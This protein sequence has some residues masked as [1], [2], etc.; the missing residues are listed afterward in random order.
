[1]G[2]IWP[3]SE[4]NYVVSLVTPEMIDTHCIVFRYQ[5][6]N[7]ITG[8]IGVSRTSSSDPSGDDRRSSG[9]KT[10][11]QRPLTALVLLLQAMV[12]T[13]VAFCQVCQEN[14]AN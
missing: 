8:S 9:H 10:L 4:D 13:Y 1:M 3:S 7:T 11:A 6:V 2:F 14:S 12:E 5:P